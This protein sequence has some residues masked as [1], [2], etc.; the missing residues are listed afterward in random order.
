MALVVG[1]VRQATD[2]RIAGLTAPDVAFVALAK[3]LADM[4][5][6]PSTANAATAKEYRATMLALVGS[7]D[8]SSSATLDGLLDGD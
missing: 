3:R 5:D 6:D 4:L 2:E 7:V 8:G 1:T